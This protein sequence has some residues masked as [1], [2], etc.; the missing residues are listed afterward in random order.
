MIRWIISSSILIVL[1]IC[2]R[3][4]FKEKIRPGLRYALWL[5]VAV[6]LL[7]PFHF[8]TSILSFEN[9]S[10]QVISRMEIEQEIQHTDLPSQK[11]GIKIY[12]GITEIRDT[13]EY[14]SELPQTVPLEDPEEYK[15]DLQPIL[16]GIWILG[17]A[18]CAVLFMMSNLRFRKE[19]YRTRILMEEQ[20]EK[21]PVYC[22]EKL[23]TPCLFG[24][25]SPAIYVTLEAA[26][27]S[28]ML[29]HTIAHELS[30]LKQGDRFWSV[31]RCLC[32][33]IHWFNPLVWVAAKLSKQDAELS[34]DAATIKKLG[35]EERAAYGKT[36]IRLTC[37][38]RQNLFVAATTMTSEKSRIKERIRLIAK[39]P[40]FR[41]YAVLLVLLVAGAA[42]AAAFT[43]GV[44]REKTVSDIEDSDTEEAEKPEEIPVQETMKQE[45]S[46]SKIDILVE[47][48]DAMQR[49]GYTEAVLTYVDNTEVGWDHYSEEP[50]A[51]EEERETLA[52][53]ALKE[54]YTLT[55]YQV[56]ECT[57]TT[58]GR[59]RFVF[60]KSEE[61]LKKSLA[62]Y[63][64]NYGFTLSGDETPEMIFVNARRFHYSDVQQVDSPFYK[65]ELEG[66]GAVPMWFLDHS[67]VYQGEEIVG[68]TATDL[69][70]TVYTH[71]KLIFDGGY[72]LVVMDEEIET[73]TEVKGPYKDSDPYAVILDQY[74]NALAAKQNGADEESS[75]PASV[76]N[77]YWSWE[78]DR[79]KE[80]L[81]KIGYAFYDLNADG[82]QELL[83]GW[84]DNEFWNLEDG[85]VFAVYTL[86]ASLEYGI[87]FLALEGWERNLYM[88]GNDGHSLYRIGSGGA[89]DSSYQ[90]GVFD[91]AEETFMRIDEELYTQWSG[92]KQ[93]IEWYYVQ[94][95]IEV[96]MDREQALKLEE[97]WEASGRNL[98]YQVF[99]DWK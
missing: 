65:K 95:G 39:K 14:V 68:F 16:L 22:V 37:E 71:I 33:V 97:Q 27:D 47:H 43:G 96:V 30:H 89:A 4:V 78:G 87:P 85:Y 62:F 40:K 79:K 34:C 50:W 93:E 74:Y 86:D 9:L 15:I 36:L 46:A 38:K 77:P 52:Q 20:R 24:L 6:R 57:Y 99:A 94:E 56:K 3:G 67:G 82:I 98:E 11:E 91:P 48:A 69:N 84:I 83:I 45:E 61:F 60:G 23:K 26:E 66:H 31:L 8:G 17:S 2:L 81:S 64:R 88:I 92:E 90:K 32:L 1:I 35:E 59:S 29:R 10:N 63:T 51:S 41:F 7:Y 75:L 73:V 72:Y 49:K 53:T 13:S 44:K 25:F 76:I 28:V 80:L 58:D 12:D 19:L 18:C 5:L 54:L 70:D 42:S 55:G 21:L